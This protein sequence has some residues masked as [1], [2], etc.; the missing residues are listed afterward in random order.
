MNMRAIQFGMALSDKEYSLKD[1]K[2]FTKV[3]FE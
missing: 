1:E 2:L 3:S